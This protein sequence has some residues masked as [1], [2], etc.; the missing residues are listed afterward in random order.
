[1][2]CRTKVKVKLIQRNSFVAS[3]V[4]T[5]LMIDTLQL[6]V[7][8]GVDLGASMGTNDI[9]CRWCTNGFIRVCAKD[10]EV[11]LLYGR[12]LAIKKKPTIRDVT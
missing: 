2:V 1:M 4:A 9:I 12:W 8:Q 6:G 7:R 3:I 5:R 10:V 11:H